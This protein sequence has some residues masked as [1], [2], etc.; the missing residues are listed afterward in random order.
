ME[1]TFKIPFDAATKAS[2]FVLFKKDAIKGE[3]TR[4]GV[5]AVMGN[6]DN[7]GD[8]IAN[9]AFAKTHKDGR[10]NIVHLW[11]HGQGEMTRVILPLTSTLSTT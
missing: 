11:D 10:K 7:I 3:R 1:N 5:Y 9:G 6:R 8:R 2:P 4:A